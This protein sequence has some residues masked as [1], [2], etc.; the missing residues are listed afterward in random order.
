[1]KWVWKTCMIILY[2]AW[3]C[4]FDKRLVNELEASCHRKG[5]AD[6]R[7]RRCP[8]ACLRFYWMAATCSSQSIWALRPPLIFSPVYTWLPRD[9]RAFYLAA[10]LSCYDPVLFLTPQIP[11]SASHVFADIGRCPILSFSGCRKSKQ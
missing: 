7:I 11:M 6:S 3:F 2:H 1:M 8:V 10:C 4:Y 5:E 9:S